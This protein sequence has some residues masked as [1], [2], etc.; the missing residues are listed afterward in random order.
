MV[1]YLKSAAGKIHIDAG[2]FH[3]RKQHGNFRPV[4]AIE[5]FTNGFLA[6][7]ITCLHTFIHIAWRQIFLFEGKLQIFRKRYILR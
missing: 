4:G 7:P 3:K 5:E 1:E 6:F 2:Y